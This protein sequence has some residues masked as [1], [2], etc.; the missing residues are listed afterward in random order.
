MR[1][2]QPF[3]GCASL[4]PF[5]SGRCRLPTPAS[6]GYSRSMHMNGDTT[7]LRLRLAGALA[8]GLLLRPAR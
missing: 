3:P 7:I 6:L 5:L 1:S 8:L 2:G 4:E